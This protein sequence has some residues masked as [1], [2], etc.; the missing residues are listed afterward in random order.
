LSVTAGSRSIYV[1]AGL[2]SAITL[3]ILAAPIYSPF[4]ALP[5]GLP[6]NPDRVITFDLG[7]LRLKAANNYLVFPWPDNSSP[8]QYQDALVRAYGQRTLDRFG[9]M[10]KDVYLSFDLPEL[11]RPTFLHGRRLIVILEYRPLQ[12]PYG[13]TVQQMAERRVPDSIVIRAP[14]MDTA[15][16]A[17]FF[18]KPGATLQHAITIG[19]FNNGVRYDEF[20]YVSK[21]GDAPQVANCSIAHFWYGQRE[22]CETLIP[23]AASAY[24]PDSAGRFPYAIGLT[25]PPEKIDQLP[26]IVRLVTDKVSGMVDPPVT[27]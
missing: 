27:P 2:C 3:L 24:P 21:F 18:L 20:R 4:I 5:R 23:F 26:H 7:P 14:D 9:S 22:E 10:E 25:F 6:H 12:Q 19:H 17:A 13:L 8:E 15:N 16:Y 11:S 1:I